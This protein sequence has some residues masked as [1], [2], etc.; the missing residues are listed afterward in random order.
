MS[1]MQ[2]ASLFAELKLKD[3]M[4]PGLKTANAS[5]GET[6][7]SAGS[8][9]K[10]LLSVTTA[11]TAAGAAAG[12]AFLAGSVTSAVA[13]E[14]SL[15]NIQAVT[16]ASSKDIAELGDT[17]NSIGA[18]S[19]AGPQA[20]AD[21]YYDI[22]GGVA[23]ASVRIA[24]L[25]AAIAVSEA[26]NADL[27]ST[28]QGMISIMNAYGFSAEQA[29]MVSDVFTQ[30]VGK[31]VGTMDDFV[32][33]MSPLG[34][35]ASTAGVD[36]DRLGAMMAYMTT[37]GTSAAQ[38]ATQ[39]KAA[40]VAVLNPNEKMKQAL[41]AMGVSSGSAAIEMYGLE[42]TLG[43]LNIAMGGSTDAMASAMGSTEAL[44]A[45]V[46]IN[47]K[48]YEE[49]LGTF[50][51]T[52]TGVTDAARAVQLQSV[53]AQFD[54]LKSQFSSIAIDVGS[55]LL[56]A[57]N[58]ILGGVNQFIADVKAKGLGVALKEW[59]EKG[60]GWLQDN[61][62]AL[63]EGA[64]KI[65]VDLGTEIGNWIITNGPNIVSGII[66]W[67]EGVGAWLRDTA[68]GLFQSALKEAMKL[69]QD[70]VAFVINNGPDIVYGIEQWAGDAWKWIQTNFGNL[71]TDSLKEG[72]KLVGDLTAT[73][74]AAAPDIG[75]AIG[76]WIRNGLTWL[77][78][79]APR[80]IQNAIA[81]LFSAKVDTTGMQGGDIAADLIPPPTVFEQ[82]A[83]SAMNIMHN[84]FETGLGLI[85]GLFDGLFG[86]K[87]GTL[88][89]I[90]EGFV[91]A[92]GPIEKLKTD[93]QTIWNSLFG[94]KGGLMTTVNAL[95]GLVEIGIGKVKTAVYA[96]M[97]GILS[98]LKTLLQALVILLDA[99][100]D[101]TNAIAVT[102]GIAAIE[103][104]ESG[105]AMGG[106]VQRGKTYLVGER[107]PELFSPDANG[108]II[109]NKA[110]FGGG[111]G[112]GSMNIGAV[113]ISGTDNPAVFFDKM[114]AE[115]K[116]RNL[117]LGGAM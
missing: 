2:V 48:G 55:V 16:G 105:K 116:R 56:P 36:F 23:D 109:T 89:G 13:F 91:G 62:P 75:F 11:L 54:L 96:V 19:V 90:F 88:K 76:S 45:A 69:G 71:L 8:A 31:G 24:T 113:Y 61:G 97:K 84:V 110:A 5:L 38:S 85:G 87:E 117:S 114:Q 49:F 46:A 77:T 40:M 25:N 1:A 82:L 27:A 57:I 107:G 100:G 52:M 20:V 98:P 66:T 28:T 42:G 103:Q 83:Q 32:A 63:F 34:G 68:P 102:G 86:L 17:L 41:K 35:L 22:A 79:E 10:S 7:N 81:G 73:I 111:G 51:D 14:K 37:K 26:G 115:A 4:T 104:F 30:T 112:G 94:E 106:P 6:A 58:A 3:T 101:K 21:A 99:M 44:Q 43:R 95:G 50:Q 18:Q 29:G 78:T 12:A 67:F 70:I 93:V 9:S 39:I 47:D 15:T 33:A 65:A 80:L 92:D 72:F 60:V 53:S 59:F 74:A 108:S 64:L